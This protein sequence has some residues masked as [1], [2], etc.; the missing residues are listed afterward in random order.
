MVVVVTA[1]CRYMLRMF[2]PDAPF[3]VILSINPIVVIILVPIFGALFRKLPAFDVILAGAFISG[4]PLT[5]QFLIHTGFMVHI[6][7]KTA[8]GILAVPTNSARRVRVLIMRARL[9]IMVSFDR[10]QLLEHRRMDH[11]MFVLCVA[12]ASFFVTPE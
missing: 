5:R 4:G 10:P 8:M 9:L 11:G 1:Y 7:F 2:G 12:S 6:I 3:G